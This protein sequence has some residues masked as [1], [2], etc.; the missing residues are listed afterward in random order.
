MPGS[1]TDLRAYERIVELLRRELSA[2]N[3][4]VLPDG[5]VP[6]VARAWIDHPLP[7]GR[8][9]YATF[10][11][12]PIEDR[13]A[14]LRRLEMLVASFQ[15]VLANVDVS[16]VEPPSRS[17]HAALTWLAERAHAVDALVVDA[18]SP[19]IWGAASDGA[20]PSLGPQPKN[21]VHLD[22][23]ARTKASQAPPPPPTHAERAI[24]A[25]RAIP[26]VAH[27]HKGG[28]LHAT[29][30]EADLGFIARSFATI[31]VLVLVFD[32]AFDELRAE[33]A[34]TQALP[35]IERLVLALPPI[36][37][38]PPVGSAAAVRRR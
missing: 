8:R 16:L 34:A 10:S 2:E 15:E 13:D 24:E 36:E 23:A 25:V 31:Y 19:V 22:P 17:L 33:R 29:V 38:D 5:I 18:Q 12:D 11:A 4:F 35:V 21:V 27:L 14:R 37:P 20:G 28:H 3:V 9:V 30:R 1:M 7:G 32:K 26:S 6:A